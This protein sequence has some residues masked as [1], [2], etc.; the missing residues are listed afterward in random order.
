[1]AE[2]TDI[3]FRAPLAGE[4]TEFR[5]DKGLLIVDGRFIPPPYHI[6]TQ[7]DG[8]VWVGELQVKIRLHDPSENDVSRRVRAG[9]R[10]VGA[11]EELR[12]YAGRRRDSTGD[13][14]DYDNRELLGAFIAGTLERGGLVASQSDEFLFATS[15]STAT[16]EF[17]VKVLNGEGATYDGENSIDIPPWLL[18]QISTLRHNQQFVA[19]S[20]AIVQQTD[21][22]AKENQASINGVRLVD[23]VAYPLSTCGMVLV[24]LATGHLLSIRPPQRHELHLAS[25]EAAANTVRFVA[26]IVAFSVLDLIWTI[27]ASQAGTMK[28]LNPLGAKLISDP[29]MLVAFKLSTL[30]VSATIL[31]YLRS[32]QRVT[33]AAWWLCLV[34]TLLT[35]RWLMFNSLLV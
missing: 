6:V 23:Q 17:I 28:E 25:P 30:T 29:T 10:F 9:N 4:L 24:V 1:M 26:M 16:C 14:D 22:I 8:T 27:L 34:L 31:F 15:T 13:V 18:A 35:A 20:D 12:R 2:I 33:L 5:I 3:R 11:N 32:H 21:R 7:S 19:L